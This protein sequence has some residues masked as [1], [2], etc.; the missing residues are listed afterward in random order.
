LTRA[1]TLLETSPQ[2][3]VYTQSYG[4]PK[5]RK[6]QFQKFQDFNLKVMGQN[7]IWVLALWPCTKN[8]IR[9]KVVASP[10][11]GHGEFF[12]ST[13]VRDSS[14]HQKCSNYALTN[15]LFGLCKSVW[16]IDPLVTHPSPHHEAPTPPSTPKMLW[17]KECT[18]IFYLFDVFTFGFAVESVKELGGASQ[19]VPNRC[20]I[21]E[22]QLFKMFRSYLQLHM[23]LFHQDYGNL[24]VTHA[25]MW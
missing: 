2:F 17:T 8:T 16:I 21:I 10:S 24:N 19:N 5:S 20:K 22:V 15:L 12:E 3:E 9:G 25:G 11:L 4:P 23:H 6:S 14:V 18:P 7:D 1:T 13:F